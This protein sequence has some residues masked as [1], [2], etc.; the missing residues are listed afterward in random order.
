MRMHLHLD[1]RGPADALGSQ[2]AQ[3]GLRE[4]H[5]AEV[6]DWRQQVLALHN[7]VEA[8]SQLLRLL[9]ALLP[10]LQRRLPPRAQAA[11]VRDALHD[12]PDLGAC[13]HRAK[14]SPHEAKLPSARCIMG[15]WRIHS[16]TARS[17]QERAAFAGTEC[18][19]NTRDGIGY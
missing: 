3:H 11:R 8:V 4:L 1:G 7:D 2:L 18:L 14:L 6:Q 10:H 16:C 9:L 15:M 12:A 5:V 13:S 19:F 17:T